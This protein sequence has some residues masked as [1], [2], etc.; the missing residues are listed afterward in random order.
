MLPTVV[1]VVALGPA[2]HPVALAGVV[3]VVL[4]PETALVGPMASAV[5]AAAVTQSSL[6]GLVATAAPAS[7]LFDTG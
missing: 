4:R 5:V 3:V 2:I 7:W 1:A 6:G